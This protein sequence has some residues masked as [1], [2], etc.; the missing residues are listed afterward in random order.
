[1]RYSF[2]VTHHDIGTVFEMD[3]RNLELANPGLEVL[4]ASEKLHEV[5]DPGRSKWRIL[6]NRLESE[7]DIFLV[8]RGQLNGRMIKIN[9]MLHHKSWCRETGRCWPPKL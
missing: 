2:R 8:D 7:K 3:M 9:L 1:M 5:E 6:R 4:D